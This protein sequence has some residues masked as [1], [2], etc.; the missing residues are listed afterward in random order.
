MNINT[1]TKVPENCLKVIFNIQD[2]LMVVLIIF[3][4]VCSMLYLRVSSRGRMLETNPVLTKTEDLE[5]FYK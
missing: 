2:I 4:A 5:D 3:H 1:L